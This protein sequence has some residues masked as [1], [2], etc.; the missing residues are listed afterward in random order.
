MSLGGT[1]SPGKPKVLGILE[2]GSSIP[3]G[4]PSVGDSNQQM[5]AR[6]RE[7]K[8]AA[9]LVGDAG[10]GVFHELWKIAEGY[11]QSNHYGIVVAT[12]EFLAR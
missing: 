8:P 4:M 11:Y 7:W 9:G 2:A 3:R 10:T 6:S 5:E 1:A 12:N